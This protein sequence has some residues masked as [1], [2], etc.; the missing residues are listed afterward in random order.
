MF[1]CRLDGILL[2]A[3]P[4]CVALRQS[5]LWP[6]HPDPSAHAVVAG[7]A[8]HLYKGVRRLSWQTALQAASLSARAARPCLSSASRARDSRAAT[9]GPPGPWGRRSQAARGTCPAPHAAN[10]PPPRD[11]RAACWRRRAPVESLPLGIPVNREKARII[12]ENRCLGAFPER[13]LVQ[14]TSRGRARDPGAA[15]G[16][17]RAAAV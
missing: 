9:R 14:N 16:R 1:L 3:D 13:R 17:R 12:R 2:P 15:R 5:R 4:P 7:D 10:R 8:A 11:R 6:L